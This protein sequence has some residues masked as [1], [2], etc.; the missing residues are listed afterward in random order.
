MNLLA[1]VE[2]NVL[3]IDDFALLRHKIWLRKTYGVDLPAEES[4]ILDAHHYT[5]IWRE[6]DRNSVYLFNTVQRRGLADFKDTVWDTVL[7]RLFNKIDTHQAIVN[8]FGDL[9]T[10]FSYPIQLYA[11]LSNRAAN[12]TGA[13]VRCPDLTQ[14]VYANNSE[15][16]E[17]VIDRVT[18]A[19]LQHD[20]QG[21][22]KALRS[23]FSIGDFLADQLMMDLTW[24]G[25]DFDNWVT[26]ASE[27]FI[28]SFGPG[29]KAGIAYCQ[30]TK[31]GSA[32]TI[33]ER[34][35]EKFQDQPMPLA[36]GNRVQY[37][38]R[39]FE[40]TLC[41]YFKHVKFQSRGTATVKMR[42]YTPANSNV[43]ALPWTW[44]APV[45]ISIKGET[46]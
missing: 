33:L 13:Y 1:N 4:K 3:M 38:A 30:E 15:A 11:F 17:P 41:E 7:F 43:A 25:G 18:E 8:Q 37:D 34:L 12:F 27:F 45:E 31:Q 21:A 39:A 28:P 10:A 46:E 16:L 26:P 20:A 19:L 44:T 29:A 24:I 35:K 5:N 22:W 14:L 36:F 32:A 9:Q 40:H 2:N 6:L 42:N 23:I